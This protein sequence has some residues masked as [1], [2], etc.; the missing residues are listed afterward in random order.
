MSSDA[1]HVDTVGGPSPTYVQMIQVLSHVSALKIRAKY[2][3]VSKGIVSI[4]TQ[5]VLIMYN[6][7]RI[8]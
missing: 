1:W 4:A 2:S 3:N 5:Y 6:I 8:E 7:L